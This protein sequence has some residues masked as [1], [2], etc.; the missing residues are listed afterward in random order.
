MVS[1]AEAKPNG[2]RKRADQDDAQRRCL[3]IS[4]RAKEVPSTTPA[5][6][7]TSPFF[8]RAPLNA[9][10]SEHTVK[11]PRASRDPS[12]VKQKKNWRQMPPLTTMARFRLQELLAQ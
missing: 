5:P 2:K 9:D 6:A 1:L 4:E 12:P 3:Y 7:P 10:H 11:S 8:S